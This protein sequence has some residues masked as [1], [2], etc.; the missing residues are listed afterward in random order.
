MDERRR[1]LIWTPEALTDLNGIW[2]YYEHV[3]G[4]STA[5]DAIREINHVCAVLTEHAY[6]GR[7]RDEIRSGL[8]SLVAGSYIIFY[9]VVAGDI[10]H[11]VRV[12]DERQDI[13]AA[14]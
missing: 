12:L 1:P 10:P 14:V 7:A 3:A 11:I 9:K 4:G 8:R 13:D 5:E 2:D 6:A